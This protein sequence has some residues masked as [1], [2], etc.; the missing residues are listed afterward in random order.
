M[1]EIHAHNLLN[2]LRE[3]PMNRDE[4]AAHFGSEARFHTCKLNDLDLDA[5]LEFLLKREKV[6]ELEGQFVVNMARVC[7][8]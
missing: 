5:L 3:T 6:R 7:N 4:L 8:H 2:L 1:T